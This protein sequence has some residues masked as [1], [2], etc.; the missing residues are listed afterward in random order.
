MRLETEGKTGV[1]LVATHVYNAIM[2]VVLFAAVLLLGWP[3]R[4]LT[5]ASAPVALALA[6]ILGTSALGHAQRF[7]GEWPET[8]RVTLDAEGEPAA[9]VLERAMREAVRGCLH[10]RDVLAVDGSLLDE[11]VCEVGMR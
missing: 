5:R 10:R 6:T 1:A 11:E 7:E 8:E 3:L 4:A 9:A 2:L